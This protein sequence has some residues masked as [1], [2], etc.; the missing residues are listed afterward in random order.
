MGATSGKQTQPPSPQYGQSVA[1]AGYSGSAPSFGGGGQAMNLGAGWGGGFQPMQGVYSYTPQQGGLPY[2]NA[3]QYGQQAGMPGGYT[4]GF[5]GNWWGQPQNT[6]G[7][8]ANGLPTPQYGG[9]G[10]AVVTP[11]APAATTANTGDYGKWGGADQVLAARNQALQAAQAAQARAGDPQYAGMTTDA[12]NKLNEQQRGGIFRNSD[13]TDL[14]RMWL[15]ANQYKQAPGQKLGMESP[16]ATTD[17]WRQA[18]NAV[19]NSDLLAATTAWGR[20]GYTGADS[21]FAALRGAAAFDQYESPFTRAYKAYM[22]IGQP[23]ATAA[24]ATPATQAVTTP[25]AT[26]P[27][28]NAGVPPSVASQPAPALQNVP[29]SKGGQ[30][31][32]PQQAQQTRQWRGWGAQ[33]Q[34]L[35]NYGALINALMGR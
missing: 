30:P 18:I 27:Q 29:W 15:Y 16:F 20:G 7:G 21:P 35:Q 4:M 14:D 24:P 17:E 13:L 31:P 12:L 6:Q 28:T 26:Q 2:T 8:S 1:Q 32:A 9:G 11:P 19:G 10:N 25:V 5:G 3:P 34:G 23:A 22:G 33:P